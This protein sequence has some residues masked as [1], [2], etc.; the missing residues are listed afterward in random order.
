MAL[1]DILM[2]TEEKMEKTVQFLI[3]EFSSVR[4]GKASPALVENLQVQAYE[5]TTM[6]LKELAGITTPEARLLMIQPWDAS[7][8]DPIRKAIEASPLGITP[9]IDGKVIRVPFPELSQQRREDLVKSIRKMAEEQRVAIRHA[10]REGIDALK[11]LEKDGKVTED[12]LES[13]E[14]EIQKLTN[15]YIETAD[16]HLASKEAELMKV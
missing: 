15:T 6:R 10:R 13:G 5:G 2:E 1:D 7:T 11:K 4:T 3:H 14:K 12:E 9:M 8:V 16:K